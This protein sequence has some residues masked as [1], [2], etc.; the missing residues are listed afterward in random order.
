MSPKRMVESRRG[1]GRVVDKRL[2]NFASRSLDRYECA[3]PIGS[4]GIKTEHDCTPLE[5]TA[6]GSREGLL[7][8][9]VK[10]MD[11]FKGTCCC[12]VNA[13]RPRGNLRFNNL[14]GYRNTAVFTAREPAWPLALPLAAH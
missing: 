14:V 4:S 10:E 1:N 7:P 12:Y 9:R 2:L 5:K 3:Y 13:S 11:C 8:A 6:E